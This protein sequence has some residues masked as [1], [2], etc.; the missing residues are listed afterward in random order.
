M[1]L[2]KIL[3]LSFFVTAFFLVGCGGS[4]GDDTPVT[5]P[6]T[7]GN[8]DDGPEMVNPSAATLI[9]PEDQTECNTGVVDPNDESMST[10]TFEWNASENTDTYSVTV[11]NLN[12]GSSTFANS[13]TNS[14]DITIMRGTPYSWFVISRATG[15][16]NT[17]E[18]ESFRFYNEGPGIENYA[19]FPAEVISP[20][21]GASLANTDMLTLEWNGSDIDDDITGYEVFFGRD[22]AALESIGTTDA[23]TTTID[24]MVTANTIYYWQVITTDG[25]ANTSSSEIFEFRVN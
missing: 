6:P 9:F 13:S 4:G 8:D 1:K 22:V 23:T 16:T 14:A 20:A 19:P 5:P 10:V 7:G 15:N 2:N 12:T 11:T 17:A 25:A 3:Y 24:V 21:R 18:S